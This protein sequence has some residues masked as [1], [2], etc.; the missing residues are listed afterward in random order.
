MMSDRFFENAKRVDLFV[1]DGQND[2]CASGNEP[3]DWPWPA[4]KPTAGA[5]CVGGADEEANRVANMIKDLKD[6]VNKR[7]HRISRIH[8]SLDS[9][10]ENDGSHNNSWKQKNGEMANPFQIVSHENVVNQ[11]FIPIIANGVFDGVPMS[12]LDWALKYTKALDERGRNP[13]CLWPKHCLIGTWGQQVYKPLFDA[14]SEWCGT[15][16]WIVNWITKGEWPFSE[17]YSALEADVPE[18]TRPDTYMN[19]GVINDAMN[20]DISIWTGWAG[21]HCLRWTGLD[22]V[23][24]F[25]PTDEEKAKGATNKFITKCVFVEDASAPVGNVP[26]G[27]DFAQWRLDFLDEMSNRGARVM[28]AADLVNAL[29]S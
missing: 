22:G 6:P 15:T 16:K 14:Y 2:F 5:L 3:N 13:L 8:A 29:K 7:N 1:I 21:S 24:Y 18:P 17:H 4:G 26:G 10:H 11:D 9:H 23:N 27:P 28:K 20:A 19:S 25:E 12:A